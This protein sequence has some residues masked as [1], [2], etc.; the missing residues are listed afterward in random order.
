M[1]GLLRCSWMLLVVLA[2]T[3]AGTAQE[4]QPSVTPADHLVQ[5]LLQAAHPELRRMS[6]ATAIRRDGEA[7]VFTVAR[8]PSQPH[9][10]L[11]RGAEILV[12]AS[13]RFS[14]GKLV[15]MTTTGALVNSDPNLR[16]LRSLRNSKRRGGDMKQT[17]DASGP[18]YGVFGQPAFEALAP[19]RE[20]EEVLGLVTV[21]SVTPAGLAVGDPDG[22]EPFGLLWQVD[23]SARQ[24]DGSVRN[25]TLNFEPFGGRLVALNAR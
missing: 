17:V 19:W 15:S 23:L 4:N 22:D 6:V 7:V 25:Y 13:S 24:T 8:A 12:T 5:Q 11:P 20:L 21:K 16:L 14:Q 9:R 18:Q 10:F 3:R 1:N 2:A